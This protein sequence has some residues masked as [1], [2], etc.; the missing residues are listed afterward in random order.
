MPQYRLFP[1]DERGHVCDPPMII[2]ARS[3]AD[4]LAQGIVL[5][6]SNNLEVWNEARRVGLIERHCG[7]RPH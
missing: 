7:N 1:I 6:D 2:T 5:V 4:A 3:D